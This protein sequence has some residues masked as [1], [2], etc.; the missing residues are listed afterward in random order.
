MG[1]E[2]SLPPPDIP[3][4]APEYRV[5]PELEFTPLPQEYGQG[6][7]PEPDRPE[8]KRRLRKL[9]AVPAIL[10]LSFLFVHVSGGSKSV[11]PSAVP[12]DLPKGSVMIDVIDYYTNIEADTVNYRY[13]LYLRESQADGVFGDPAMPWPVEVTATVTDEDGNVAASTENPDIWTE[14]RSLGEHTIDA[15]GLKGSLILRLR[16]EYTQDGEQRQTTVYVPLCRDPGECYFMIDYAMLD[17]SDRRVTFEY[18][19]DRK[20][21][22]EMIVPVEATLIDSEGRTAHP[23][24]D[25]V[26]WSSDPYLDPDCK[27]IDAADLNDNLTLILK[28]EYTGEDGRQHQS[29]AAR[30]VVIIGKST[31]FEDP[32]FETAA[33]I[34][35]LSRSDVSFTA[36]FKTTQDS[37]SY[38]DMT[39]NALSLVWQDENGEELYRDYLDADSVQSEESF[40]FAKSPPWGEW[41]D[42]SF[43]YSGKHWFYDSTYYDKSEYIGKEKS[44]YAELTLFNRF[45]GRRYTLRSEPV[46]AP[47]EVNYPLG[48]GEIVITVY[49]D[50]TTFE[51]PTVVSSGGYLTAL[52]RTTIAESDF[53][54][55]TMPSALTPSGYDFAGWVVHVGNPFTDDTAAELYTEF[56]GDPPVDR[57]LG[58]GNYAFAVGTTLTKEDIEKVPPSGDGKRWVDVHAVWIEKNPSQK[59]LRLDDGLGNVAEY[60][61]MVPLASEGYLY[62][63]RYPVPEREGYVFDGWYN[64]SGERVDL[65]LC[66]FSFT[67]M[68][69]DANGSFTGYD[70]SRS[71]AVTLT[72][73]WRKG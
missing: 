50:T 54:S 24:V 8:K 57:L 29:M 40:D 26:M 35:A 5:D 61:M 53:T 59:L 3:L 13:Q 49:N 62:L 4:S 51:F 70:W 39:P 68:T 37:G 7:S 60:G 64:E 16:A 48:D 73:H 20:G 22:A 14:G 9:L 41:P 21:S 25:P 19:V 72:A 56:S 69:Y 67:P 34:T 18:W 17:P 47:Q 58:E 1:A 15:A 63:C 36:A 32:Q 45:D 31:E 23:K 33:A 44:V 11:K 66:Y 10:L 71:E 55:Y 2:Y 46:P 6:T 12:D 52:A 30:Q 65:L 42:W 43:S 28:T 27:W 38:F